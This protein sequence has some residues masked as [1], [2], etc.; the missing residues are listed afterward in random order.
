MDNST[1]C[2]THLKN[3]NPTASSLKIFC[4]L[5][6]S[7][8]HVKSYLLRSLFT[9]SLLPPVDHQHLQFSCTAKFVCLVMVDIVIVSEIFCHF[10]KCCHF[11]ATVC[12][13]VRP[14]ISLRC[15]S[16]CLSCPVCN[17]GVLWPDGWMDQ[18]ETWHAGRPRPWPHCVRWGP[19]CPSHKGAQPPI[20]GPYLLCPNGWVDQDATWCGDRLRPKRHCVRWGTSSP[21]PKRVS[22]LQFLAHVYCGQLMHGSRCHLVWR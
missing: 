9:L 4:I 13:T 10:N 18:D 20:F 16:V 15:L 11:W 7:S 14:I 17:V 6:L 2:N 3:S 21:S 8:L 5:V 19:R 1:F 22:A 12:K